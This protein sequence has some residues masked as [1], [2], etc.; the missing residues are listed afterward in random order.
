MLE[1]TPNEFSYKVF[2]APKTKITESDLVNAIVV[3]KNYWT[4]KDLEKSIAKVGYSPK[5]CSALTNLE[6]P[7]VTTLGSTKYPEA[8][9][10]K[11]FAYDI[12]NECLTASQYQML[13]NTG[14]L[15]INTIIPIKRVKRRTS[16]SSVEMFI[17]ILKRYPKTTQSRILIRYLNKLLKEYTNGI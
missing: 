9:Y 3:F 14:Q 2:T 12:P 13:L 6:N 1:L 15:L 5:I 16:K 11:L 8:K 7:L 17:S 10:V 4:A